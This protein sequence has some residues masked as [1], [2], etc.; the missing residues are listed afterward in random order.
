MLTREV[1]TEIEITAPPQVV[2]GVLS[3]LE[4]WSEW[5]PL[6]MGVRLRGPLRRGTRGRLTI[7][8]GSPVGR[9]S[10]TVRLVT[11]RPPYEL[12]W[13]GGV[14]GLLRGCHR[15]RLEPAPT[16][17]RLVHTE[18]FSGVL[19]P[20]L[21]RALRGWLGKGYRQLDEGLR[22]RCESLAAG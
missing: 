18:A 15:F 11:V 7:D 6:I 13:A 8:L 16:G 4:A 17:T 12:A 2:W 3:K 20:A 1:R 22:Q 21:V 14:R 5:N 9:Q 19:A 10:L